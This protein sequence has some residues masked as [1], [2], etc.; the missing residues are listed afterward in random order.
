[1]EG[2]STQTACAY[3]EWIDTERART[4]TR[5]GAA[6]AGDKRRLHGALRFSWHTVTGTTVCECQLT[7]M[8]EAA[9]VH[10]PRCSPAKHAARGTRL[11]KR[12]DRREAAI[13]AAQEERRLVVTRQ[14]RGG[15]HP[16]ARGGSDCDPKALI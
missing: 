5:V 10:V 11:A 7:C 12:R 15:R 9:R 13:L 16:P 14:A 2:V 3:A 6:C 1:M 4:R 8:R